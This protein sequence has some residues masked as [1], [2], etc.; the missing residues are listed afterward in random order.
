MARN[1]IGQTTA[2]CRLVTG[3]VPAAPDS[4]DG[5]ETSDTEILLRWK[6]PRHDGN[7]TVLC[8]GLQMRKATDSDWTLL[9]ENIDHEFFLIRSLEPDTEYQFRLAARNRF[10]WSEKSIPTDPIS[11]KSVGSA[12]V[13]VTRAMKYLQQLTESRTEPIVA[14]S[15]EEEAS[16][17]VD[18]A[19]ETEPQEIKTGPP[20][21]DYRFIAEINRGRFSMI[22]K[23]SDK[24]ANKMYAAKIVKKDFNSLEELKIAR[25]LCH[26]RIAAVHQVLIPFFSIIAKLEKWL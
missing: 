11:T 3:D 20:T 10:G 17:M 9:A 2:K 24:E 7:A 19:A 18:F 4:P 14:E 25:T 6:V 13:S 22:A 12:K 15:H 16:K 21:D 26:E 5:S 1:K 23:C 8:Y